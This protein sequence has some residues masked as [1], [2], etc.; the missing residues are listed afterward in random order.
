V[1]APL[2]PAWRQAVNGF[3]SHKG[4]LWRWQIDHCMATAEVGLEC[5]FE[6]AGSPDRLIGNVCLSLSGSVGILGHVFV[7]PEQRGRGVARS[8]LQRALAE[9][10]GCRLYL[11]CKP[12]LESLYAQVGFESLCPGFMRRGGPPPR[13][14]GPTRR[15]ALHWRHWPALVEWG[16]GRPDPQCLEG[17]VLKLIRASSPAWVEVCDGQVVSWS[18]DCE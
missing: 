6:L 8:L 10:E 3:L 14:T 17:P 13:P 7:A 4:D 18:E 1:L 16:A 12:P 5:H 15:E 9:R 11:G 2:S